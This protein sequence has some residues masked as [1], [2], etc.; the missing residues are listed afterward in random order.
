VTIGKPEFWVQ[1]R[2]GG[3]E[4]DWFRIARCRSIGKAR[5]VIE[6]RGTKNPAIRYRIIRVQEVR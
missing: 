3:W 4:R 2:I 5:R 6:K 1:M